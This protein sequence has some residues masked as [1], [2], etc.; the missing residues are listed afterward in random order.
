MNDASVFV[1]TLNGQKEDATG[2]PATPRESVCLCGNRCGDDRR[3]NAEM[4]KEE[5]KKKA[6]RTETHFGSFSNEIDVVSVSE[7]R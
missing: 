5:Q 6:G 3:R 1:H 4:E 2:R 7:E